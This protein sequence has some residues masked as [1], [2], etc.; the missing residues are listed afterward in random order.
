[1]IRK[2]DNSINREAEALPFKHQAKAKS[3][4]RQSELSQDVEKRRW[5]GNIPVFLV[6]L[7][8]KGLT[9]SVLVTI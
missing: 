3:A 1:M 2:I 5:Q 4:K 9:T 7:C 6:Q 8:R